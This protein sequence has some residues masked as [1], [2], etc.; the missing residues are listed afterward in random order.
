M[1]SHRQAVNLPNSELVQLIR[2]NNSAFDR[3]E[4]NL[5]SASGGQIPQTLLITSCNSGEG[6]TT[7]VAG[8]GVSMAARGT[9]NV[10][11]VDAHIRQPRL[12]SLF[13]LEN[14]PGLAEVVLMNLSWQEA[15]RIYS[16]SN[17]HVLS[18]GK[19]SENPLLIFRSPRFASTLEELKEH[20][21]CI[22]FDGPPFLS[23]PECAH[24]APMFQGVLLVV[25]CEQTRWQLVSLV[26]SKIET[27]HGKVLGCIMNRRKYYIPNFLYRVS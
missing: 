14:S 19:H 25:A 1:D 8:I 2:K 17:L 4:G 12:H 27:A 11:L 16:D 9:N 6:K 5:L 15:I 13:E 7:S 22:I 3:F 20:Y 24:I 10:L 23:A 21:N 26:K 18:A